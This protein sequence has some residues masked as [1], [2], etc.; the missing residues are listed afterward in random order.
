ML[1]GRQQGSCVAFKDTGENSKTISVLL[2]RYL[3][4]FAYYCSLYH[5]ERRAALVHLPTSGPLASADRLVPLLQ[6]LLRTM[7]A[8]LEDL[9]GPERAEPSKRNT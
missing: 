7:L 6:T 2:L 3:C 9:P 4:D 5:G 1:G 8:Q